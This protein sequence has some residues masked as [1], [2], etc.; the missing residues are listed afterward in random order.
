MQRGWIKLH[1]QVRN[2]WLFEE[3]RTF[4]KFEAWVDLLMEVN[5]KDNNFLLG[6][7]LMELKVGQTVTSVRKLCDKW[8]WSNT[9]VTQFLKLL[10]NE[11]MITYKSDT[12][13]TVITIDKYEF[14]QHELK[15]ETTP[16][17]H[18]HD[19]KQTRK[20]TNKNDK[21][22]KNENNELNNNSRKPVYDEI[23]FK[24]S[25]LLFNKILE[26]NPNHRKVNLESW[27]PHIRLMMERDKRTEEQIIYVINWVSSDSFWS[28]VILSTKKLREKFDTIIA[29]IKA[30]QNK[31]TPIRSKTT[32]FQPSEEGRKRLE[33][34][35]NMTAEEIEEMDR[36]LKEELEEMPY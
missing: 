26:N 17:T 18:E 34:I 3:K 12:K 14:Y 31:V 11:G 7:D 33:A 10:Q 28:G 9:K 36:K 4:S 8:G 20:H 23:H 5:H 6:N 35:N 24:L 13:K 22:E 27:A 15:E 29:Q 25:E 1:R 19:K 30:R 2:H 21:N 16:N 32:K